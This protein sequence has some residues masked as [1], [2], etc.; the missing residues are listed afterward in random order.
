MSTFRVTLALEFDQGVQDTDLAEE[1][2]ELALKA[3]ASVLEAHG[4]TVNIDDVEQTS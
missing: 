4:L 1:T 3:G 2:L